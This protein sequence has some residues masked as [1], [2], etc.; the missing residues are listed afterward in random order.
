MGLLAAVLLLAGPPVRMEFKEASWEQVFGWL[1]RQLDVT[2]S[3]DFTPPGTFT[4]A[5]VKACS[6]ETALELIHGV[7]LDRGVTLVR[8]DKGLVAMR[9]ADD[10]HRDLV[11]FV[12]A[13]DLPRTVGNQI[14][15]TVVRLN[16]LQPKD[17]EREFREALSPRGR[18]AATALASR[19]TVWDRTDVL[20]TLVRLLAAI[21][22]P[23][24][25][26]VVPLRSFQLKH[27]NAAAA[28]KVLEEMFGLP[29]TQ[30]AGGP[31]AGIVPDFNKMGEQLGNRQMLEAF[32]PGVS[33]KGVVRDTPRDPVPL[34]LGIH[35]D[36]NALYVS[37]DPEKL[38]L[39]EELVRRLDSPAPPPEPGRD[40]V[41][42]TYSLP[43]GGGVELAERIRKAH[44]GDAGFSVAGT[45]D[46]LIVR[47]TRQR[48][49]DLDRTVPRMATAVAQVSVWNLRG[50]DAAEVARQLQQLFS[51]ESEDSRPSIT[52]DAATNRLVVRG[53]A[54]QRAAIAQVIAGYLEAPSSSA[55]AAP[56]AREGR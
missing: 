25:G 56:A 47:G 13:A 27:A 6:V 28:A 40:I 41:E 44:R 31:L 5:D 26:R 43:G 42:R 48:I 37:G 52:G 22:P 53:S 4:Y 12:P 45:D 18:I 32:V 20:R 46:R 54:G 10:V 3:A 14:V 50:A 55:A 36:R 8:R 9:L 1:G 30:A 49:A 19:I 38:S 17:A 2:V 35:T 15:M 29:P 34:R 33:F 23:T 39:I 51:G 16:Q 21:D 24:G 7:L 11:P